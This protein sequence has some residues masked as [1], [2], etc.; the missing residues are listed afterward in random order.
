MVDMAW[1]KIFQAVLCPTQLFQWNWFA[2]STNTVLATQFPT[3]FNSTLLCFPTNCSKCCYIDTLFFKM[4]HTLKTRLNTQIPI[5]MSSVDLL[6]G[7]LVLLLDKT[8]YVP[9]E[10]RPKF[11]DSQNFYFHFHYKLYCIQAVHFSDKLSLM[12]PRIW[13]IED[14]CIGIYVLKRL[15]TVRHILKKV[16]SMQHSFEA[17]SGKQRRVEL[18]SV[19]NF[20]A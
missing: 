9:Q 1:K 2:L 12:C 16:M 17:F 15:L 6:K 20:V 13:P 5:H 7:K 3:D 10:T 18:K 8:G 4:C 19:G 14:I 11:I